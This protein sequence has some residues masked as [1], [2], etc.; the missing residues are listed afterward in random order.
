[1]CFKC[2]ILNRFIAYILCVL[3][4]KLMDTEDSLVICS[5]MDMGVG[6]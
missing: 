3:A 5:K 1:M 6:T 4:Y 2:N